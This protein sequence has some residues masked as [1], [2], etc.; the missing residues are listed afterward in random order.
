MDCVFVCDMIVF[1]WLMVESELSVAS[2]LLCLF[3]DCGVR[4]WLVVAL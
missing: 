3:I 4:L 1:I 2:F